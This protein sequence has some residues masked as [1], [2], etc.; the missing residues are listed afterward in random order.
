MIVIGLWYCLILMQELYGIKMHYMDLGLMAVSRKDLRLK[1]SP[2]SW[3][4][5]SRYC[6]IR[7][8][9]SGSMGGPVGT[10]SLFFT[11][12]SLVTGSAL[13]TARPK[14]TT[15]QLNPTFILVGHSRID[16]PTSALI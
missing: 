14:S 12:G 15:R 16:L 9:S 2:Y 8:G 5:V 13:Q 10:L 1:R 11:A 7:R 4:N 6:S 3:S